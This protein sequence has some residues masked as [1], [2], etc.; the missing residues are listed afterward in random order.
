[1]Q[2]GHSEDLNMSG[3]QIMTYPAPVLRKNSRCIRKFNESL[4]QLVKEMFETMY[5]GGGVGLAAPQVGKSKK[6]IVIDTLEPG[7]RLALANPKILWTSKETEPF[8]EGCLSLPGLEGEIVRPKEVR[9]RA[10]R[11]G[12]GEI[13]TITADGLLARVLQHEIDH[14]EG[15]LFIDYLNDEERSSLE[16]ALREME[17]A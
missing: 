16:P 6:L 7:G 13:I 10:Q 14:L 15:V 11:P 8:N 2:R 12:D 1:M 17:A 3:L 4:Q 9:V 5:E